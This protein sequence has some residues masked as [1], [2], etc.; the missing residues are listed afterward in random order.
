[1]R[2]RTITFAD[3]LKRAMHKGLIAET[4]DEKELRKLVKKY[5]VCYSC[6]F[7]SIFTSICIFF[8]ERK[9][10]SKLAKMRTGTI[11]FDEN[12][13]KYMSNAFRTLCE[14][15]HAYDG[16]IIELGGRKQAKKIV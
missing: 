6:S 12:S 11:Y 7:N 1:M 13:I 14:A 15:I 3:V 16:A 10:W 4:S 8:W 9:L 2:M 5:G